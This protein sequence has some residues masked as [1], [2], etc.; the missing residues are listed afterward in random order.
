M[1]SSDLRRGKPCLYKL[2]CVKTSLG[3]SI[4]LKLCRYGQMQPPNFTLFTFECYESL[5]TY[6]TFI[7]PFIGG[8]LVS[9]RTDLEE[10]TRTFCDVLYDIGL[11]F[12]IQ[13]DYLDV[14]GDSKVTGKVGTDIQ[15][16]KLTWLTAKILILLSDEDK[17][18]YGLNDTHCI[19]TIR[20]LYEKY[21][22]QKCYQ[23]AIDGLIE[24]TMTKIE[25]TSPPS[26]A[27][28]YQSYLNSIRMRQK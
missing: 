23:T 3:E 13:D 15:E 12:Q 14:Y 24:T 6:Y 22:I 28:Y 21:D 5:T 26:F 10:F 25:Q 20:K 17:N 1:D 4:D 19:D 16:G 27:A 7:F 11:I 18:C 9:S 8:Y 2:T